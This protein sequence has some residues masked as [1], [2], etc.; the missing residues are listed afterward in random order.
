MTLLVASVF[1]SNERTPKWYELQIKYLSQNTSHFEHTAFINGSVDPSI[2]HS[3]EVVFCEN[4]DA[5]HSDHGVDQSNNHALALN[6]IVEYFRNHKADNYLILDSDCFPISNNW[7]KQ[8]LQIMN[9]QTEYSPVISAPIRYENLDNF[10]HPSAMFIKGEA[11]HEKW[12]NFTPQPSKN[13]LQFPISEVCATFPK[14]KCYPLVR[15]NYY[16]PHP[17]FSAIYNHMFY[18]HACGS[19][20]LMP[21]SMNYYNHILNQMN[22]T[23]LNAELYEEITSNTDSYLSKLM[24][25]VATR[26][27]LL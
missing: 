23:N 25:G 1:I 3:S 7:D 6:K 5:A 14:E 19:R 12:I 22:Y 24:Y 13:M 2:F 11:I 26:K 21:R 15:T 8:L 9:S 27:I 17:L 18:H 16:N 4:Q 20:H 10:P